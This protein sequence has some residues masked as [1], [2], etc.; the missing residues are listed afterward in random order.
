MLDIFS[1]SFEIL[2]ER[3]RKR[4]FVGIFCF[5]F[6]NA[7]RE[8]ETEKVRLVAKDK[9]TNGKDLTAG[10]RTFF[11]AEKRAAVAL[12]ALSNCIPAFAEDEEFR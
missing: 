8:R 9:L 1:A 4:T 10:V 7:E 3:E 5:V 2:L 12:A 6:T 11:I